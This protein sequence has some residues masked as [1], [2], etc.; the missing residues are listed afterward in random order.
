MSKLVI[1]ILSIAGEIAV[2]AA[3][4]VIYLMYS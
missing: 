1:T 3:G 4:F 2:I